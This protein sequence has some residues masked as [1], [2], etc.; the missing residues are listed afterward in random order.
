MDIRLGIYANLVSTVLR[1]K[2]G[3]TQL[4]VTA[5]GVNTG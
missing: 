4:I 2:N 3:V 5:V 1:M